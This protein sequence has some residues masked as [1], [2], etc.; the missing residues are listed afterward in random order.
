MIHAQG[1]TKSFGTTKVLRG[2]DVHIDEG[3]FVAIMGPS[4]SGKSTLL[5]ALSGIDTP[6]EGTIELLG[7]E[8]TTMSQ[9]QLADLRLRDLGF[10]FQQPRLVATLNLLDNVVL[11]AAV[12]GGQPR[13]EIVERAQQLL[14]GADVSELAD[15]DISQASGGQLQRVAVCRALIGRPK[16][17]FCDEPTGALNSANAAR[18]LELI[19]REAE[20]GT[21]VVMVTHDP[22]V[23][24]AA[25]RVLMLKDGQILGD[26]RMDGDPA[27]RR[28]E[29]LHW[30]E[31]AEV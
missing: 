17:L 14:A 11:P 30:L 18:V 2:I 20:A 8:I 26:R 10:V 25:D 4:G 13:E 15:R 19:A 21:T 9:P 24:A 31:A 6:D 23:A 22:T 27:T 3:E 5:Y 1:I 28:A 29:V 12:A 16:V 7:H